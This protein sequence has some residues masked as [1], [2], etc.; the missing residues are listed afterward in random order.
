V[1]HKIIKTNS[2]LNA[3][4]VYQEG[5]IED[6]SLSTGVSDELTKSE[7]LAKVWAAPNVLVGGS[8]S[9]DCRLCIQT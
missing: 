9:S 5:S 8:H 2:I 6:F 4:I 1:V 3:Q 7:R